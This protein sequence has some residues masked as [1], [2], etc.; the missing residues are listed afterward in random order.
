M[1]KSTRIALGLRTGPMRPNRRRRFKRI[2]QLT[3]FDA[4][5]IST[6]GITLILTAATLI[7]T[8]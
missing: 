7:L 3:I 8:D 5:A 2:Q 1:R 6:I 4:I